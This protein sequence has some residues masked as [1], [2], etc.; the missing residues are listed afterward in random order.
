MSQPKG[1]FTGKVVKVQD[2]DAI[3]VQD[4]SR[5]ERWVR[6]MAVDA[7]EAGQPYYQEASQRLRDLV[8]NKRVTVQ[9]YGLDKWG[10]HIG[11]VYQTDAGESRQEVGYQLV[12]EGHVFVWEGVG[13]YGDLFNPYIEAEQR[14]R[15]ERKG[16]WKDNPDPERP[17]VYRRRLRD[18]EEDDRE[19]D[20]SPKGRWPERG[21]RQTDR[22]VLPEDEPEVVGGVP[23]L[24]Q[25]GEQNPN[26]PPS[27]PQP[28]RPRRSLE[29]A[30]ARLRKDSRF[31]ITLLQGEGGN[32][33]Y[34]F[35]LLPAID[36][37]FRASG[38]PVPETSPGIK[39]MTEMNYQRHLV[40]GGPPVYQSLGIK[41]RYLMLV[42][43]LIGNDGFRGNPRH[44]ALDISGDGRRR[45]TPGLNSYRS[46]LDLDYDLVQAGRPVSVRI[47]SESDVPDAS[48][49][50]R[51]YGIIESVRFY[52]TRADRTYYAI[53]LS[54]LWWPEK[55]EDGDKEGKT[56]TKT[57]S[58]TES[59]AP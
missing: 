34:R 31:S 46:A 58:S 13:K 45:G 59:K 2:G 5:N 32:K 56:E 20:E 54:N 9:Y 44:S 53:T 17:E 16:L 43:T 41:G 6:F 3:L 48:L 7:P 50:V 25:D 15:Q 49:T 26:P 36:S 10:R 42:G 55:D 52:C 22:Y 39:F 1:S 29:Q 51:F 24:I 18:S 11:L 38:I 23:T 47:Y 35:A 21:E 30:L 28:E 57:E 14:A 33:T 4:D 8:L 12:Q 40:P 19:V 37:A 27:P